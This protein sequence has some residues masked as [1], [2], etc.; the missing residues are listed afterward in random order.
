MKHSRAVCGISIIAVWINIVFGMLVMAEE[1][2]I[3]YVVAVRGEVV[4][5]DMNGEARPLAIKSPLYV[6]DTVKT[7]NRSRIQMM[8]SDNTLI[9]LGQRTEMKLSEYAW[10]PENDVGKMRTQ[11]KEGAFRVMGGAIT[12]IAPK[13]FKTETPSAT[14]GIR[15]SMYAGIVREGRL[16]VLFEGGRGIDVTNHAGSVAITRR[17][18]GTV[19]RALDQA[20]EEPVR[21]SGKDLADINDAFIDQP[22]PSDEQPEQDDQRE[23][24]STTDQSEGNVEVERSGTTEEHEGD[25]ETDG[26]R[27]IEEPEVNEDVNK[28]GTTE[29]TEYANLSDFDVETDLPSTTLSETGSVH[30]GDVDDPLNTAKESVE[31]NTEDTDRSDETLTN[32]ETSTGDETSTDDGT[33]SDDGPP[34]NNVSPTEQAILGLLGELGFTGDRSNSVSRQGIEG[35]EGVTRIEG[36][37]D[38]KILKAG[39]NWHNGRFMG[40]VEDNDAQDTK[41]TA[42]FFGEVSG[43]SLYNLQIVGLGFEEDTTRVT[44]FSGGETF[45]QLYGEQNEAFGL[46]VEGIEVNVKDQS[47]QESWSGISAGLRTGE[48]SSDVPSGTSVWNGFVVGLGEDMGQPDVDEKLFMNSS[49]SELQLTVNKDQGTINGSLSAGDV[50]G[51]GMFINNLTVGGPS[52]SSSAYVDDMSMIALLSGGSAITDASRNTGGLKP[53]GNYMVTAG[54][55]EKT[56][57]Y[58]SWGYW[59]IAYEEPGTGKDYHVHVPG[60]M[61]VAGDQTP[62]SVIEGLSANGVTGTYKGGATGVK[63]D[64]NGRMSDLTGGITDLTIDFDPNAG[65]PV[66]GNISFDQ[67]VLEVGRDP[68]ELFST[69]FTAPIAGATSSSINGTFFGPNAEAIGGNFF[70]DMISGE[71]YH[72]LFGGERIDMPPAIGQ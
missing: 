7:G 33:S 49:S 9:S 71:K 35:Y 61:W 42:F 45:G 58:L 13:Q 52:T 12:R 43:T 39:I 57:E 6:R 19:V 44:T 63:V 67:V 40:V 29:E 37:E 10:Q 41:G 34:A 72:G 21:F 8:F 28:A 18:F 16:S 27:T 50:Y 47:E 64:L 69:G 24:T 62:E 38:D 70:A 48:G 59:E 3:G 25:V 17:G 23:E 46:A 65:S 1:T 55:G 56:S 36:D 5:E 51:S 15:G 22:E 11:V 68:G 4:A 26:T 2:R 32:N 31:T 14:I 60:A 30:V 53:Y 20:P 54:P 66:S